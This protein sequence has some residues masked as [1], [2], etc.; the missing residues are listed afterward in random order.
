MRK[1][2]HYVI[3]L[4]VMVM[5]VSC[6][7]KNKPVEHEPGTI[8]VANDLENMAWINLQTLSKDVA[9]SGRFSSRLD[10]LTE[11]S[12]GYSNT[13]SN[14]SDTLPFSVDV[15]LWIYYPELKINSSLVISIDSVNKNIFWKGIPLIDSIKTAN[16]WQKINVTFE[17]PKK[18]MPTDQLR[19]YVLNNEKRKF[20][21]DDLSLLF[22]NQ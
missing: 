22:H 14:L 21:M 19:I 18:I 13:F 5:F 10:S 20:Y 12:F 2:L 7:E 8:L 3:L 11:F 9:H 4:V 1:N 17:L 6:S 15:S 16:Q